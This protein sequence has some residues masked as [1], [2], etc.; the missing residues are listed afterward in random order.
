MVSGNQVQVNQMWGM[1]EDEGRITETGK[2]EKSKKDYIKN[3]LDITSTVN[4]M[5]K[6]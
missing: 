4:L 3:T 5:A 6:V 2:K 1:F